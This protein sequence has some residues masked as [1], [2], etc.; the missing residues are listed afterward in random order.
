MRSNRLQI[1]GDMAERGDHI[2]GVSAMDLR[3]GGVT[4]VMRIVRHLERNVVNRGAP[5]ATYQ[6]VAT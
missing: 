4:E 1:M 6:M 5:T 2:N 3:I